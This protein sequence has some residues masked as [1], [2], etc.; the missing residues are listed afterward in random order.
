MSP[1]A[2]RVTADGC[3]PVWFRMLSMESKLNRRTKRAALRATQAWSPAERLEA[4]LTHCRL[5]ADLHNAG[6]A[7]RLEQGGRGLPSHVTA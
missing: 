4:F 7:N 3:T 1:A 2:T 6:Q 5:M